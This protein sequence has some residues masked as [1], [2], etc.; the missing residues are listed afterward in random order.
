VDSRPPQRLMPTLLLLAG[1]TLG[2]RGLSGG[3]RAKQAAGPPDLALL[4]SRLSL[5]SRVHPQTGVTISEGRFAVPED[6]ASGKGRLIHLPVV[7]LRAKSATPRPDPLFVF[8]G[9]PGSDVTQSQRGYLDAGTVDRL[10]VSCTK[11]IKPAR[12]Q[13]TAGR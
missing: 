1:A 6:R 13:L 2:A 7:V 8:T 5:A 9:A 11:D 12:F 10:D 3:G 4:R